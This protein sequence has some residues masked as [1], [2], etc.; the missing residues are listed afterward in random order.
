MYAYAIHNER[1]T[2]SNWT[3]S[4]QQFKN[5]LARYQAT[6]EYRRQETNVA[7]IYNRPSRATKDPIGRT[8]YITFA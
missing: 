3:K 4:D 6:A 7:Q 2:V 5:C 8:I 1:L